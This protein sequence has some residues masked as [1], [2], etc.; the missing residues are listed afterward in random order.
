MTHFQVADEP[1]NEHQI[2]RAAPENPVRDRD[3]PAPGKRDTPAPSHRDKYARSQAAVRDHRSST[4]PSR[5][6][7]SA[8]Q[9]TV[10]RAGRTVLDA[11]SLSV[12]RESRLGIVGPNGV[13]KST[14]LRVLA[15]AQIPD[16]GR[17]ERAPASLR[18]AFL[19]Q[20]TDGR[21]GE[22]LMEYL[23]RR[24]G[25]TDASL[26]LDRLTELLARDP[27][28]VDDYTE[29]LENFLSVGGDDFPTRA[30]EIIRDVELSADKADVPIAEMSGGQ[31]ARARLA[32]VESGCQALTV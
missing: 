21:P 32:A 18:I 23:A 20:E 31:A 16:G 28:V 14:L 9:V 17:V 30:A 1:G 29:A 8:Q 22:L 19:P 3:V 24:T 10:T 7:L 15:G 2:E 6:V 11:V 26:E 12:D 4:Y 25:V 27:G 5:A 13:G